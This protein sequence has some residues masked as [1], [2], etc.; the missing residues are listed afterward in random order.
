MPEVRR[1]VETEFRRGAS[2]PLVPFPAESS[3][4]PDS[5]RLTLVIG[6]PDWEWS[7]RGALSQ[8][9]EEWT[10]R[11]GGSD[12]L[13]PGA[14]VWCLRRPGRGLREKVELLLAW[15]RVR[16]EVDS[17]VLGSDFDKAD[18]AEIR[19]EVATA[20]SDVRDEVWAEYRYVLLTDPASQNGLRVIDL[21]AGHSSANE[22]LAGRVLQA[23]RQEALVNESFGAG[24]LERHW[25]PAFEQSGEWP[26]SSLRQAFINGTL[27][28][29][30]DPERALRAKIA[31]LVQ[32]GDLGLASRRRPDGAYER[33]WFAEPVPAD[34]IAFEGDVY[35]LKKAAAQ[36][37]Q[38]ATHEGE[39]RPDE[40]PR[41]ISHVPQEQPALPG[42][43]EGPQ[44]NV[45][46]G[47][48]TV[49]LMGSLNPEVWNRFG[50]RVIAK[51]R[52]AGE[53][54]VSVEL[55]V[56]VDQQAYRQLELDLKQ[57][58]DDVGL[59]QSLRVEDS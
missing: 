39:P 46:P 27:T 9:V 51:L 37:V 54:R 7:S 35:L 16:T 10:K 6:D 44:P 29:L 20:E 42:G 28:R 41:E 32:S 3:D 52:S 48:R 33:L 36:R 34:E 12:R 2:L 19:E 57:T 15:R 24:Y 4:I 55:S 43:G 11:R 47:R 31:E 8:T 59:G 23:L 56:E 22:T 21:G 49:R 1:V 18:L 5:P 50:T 13:Y 14:L 17:G 53:V 25:P 40:Q 45:A 38:R 26:L 58:L 30:I